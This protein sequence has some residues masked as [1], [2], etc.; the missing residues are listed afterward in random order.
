MSLRKRANSRGLKGRLSRARRVR[1]VASLLILSSILVVSPAIRF[2]SNTDLPIISQVLPLVE[3]VEANATCALG[4]A[5]VAG[6]TGPGGGIVFYVAPTT[7]ASTGSACTPNCKYLEAAP[8]GWGNGI[9]VG[10]G[11]TSGTTTR[12]PVLRWCHQTADSQSTKNY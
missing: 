10:G 6:N 8:V 11:E 9:T 7:F 2:E 12:D 3:P 4:G 1:F 5:C